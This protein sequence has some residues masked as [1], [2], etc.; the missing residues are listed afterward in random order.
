MKV[1]LHNIERQTEDP[2]TYS[3]SVSFGDSAPTSYRASFDDSD[4]RARFCNVEPEL[5]MELSNLAH[6]RFCDCTVY[7]VE[8]MSIIGAFASD[9]MDLTLPVQ[10]GTT[11]YC[12]SKPTRSK[13]FR[14][15]LYYWYTMLKWRLGIGRPKWN[16]VTD[17]NTAG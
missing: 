13:I 15:K 4:P 1:V 16:D 8:L 9:G 6:K 7:Q 17:V 3:V 2:R 12:W 10:L 14:N 11:Q 5:F